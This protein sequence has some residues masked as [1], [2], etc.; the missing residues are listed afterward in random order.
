M[1]NKIS[2]GTRLNNALASRNVKQK[3]LAR[4][5]NVPD[6]TISY[7]CKDKRTP[8]VRQIAEIAKRLEVSADYLLGVS[9][10]MTTDTAT[11]ELCL[12][13]G[14]SESTVDLLRGD[15]KDSKMVEIL[16]DW[17]QIV[18]GNFRLV[19]NFLAKDQI[20]CARVMERS[21]SDSLRSFEIALKMK[22]DK[23]IQS[24]ADSIELWDKS[25]EKTDVQVLMNA[26]T[27]EYWEIC[28]KD[29]LLTSA[30]QEMCMLLTAKKQKSMR[31]EGESET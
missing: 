21:L 30:I 2:L 8:N 23:F 3:E 25:G 31:G 24:W 28:P 13:L 7:F 14:L 15:I 9:D 17:P 19:V 27:D 6:N 29:A 1:D 20:E 18:S 16:K 11:R 5:L 10:V 4:Y 12:T 26:Y 22:N